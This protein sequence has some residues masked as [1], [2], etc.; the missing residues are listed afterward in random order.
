M[1][2]LLAS[3][4][5]RLFLLRPFTVLTRQTRQAVQAIKQSISLD[6]YVSTQGTGPTRKIRVVIRYLF[7]DGNT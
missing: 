4:H 6:V 2:P 5:E 7:T 1:F 3:P